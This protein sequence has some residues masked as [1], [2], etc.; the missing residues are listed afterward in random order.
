MRMKK[1]KTR[2]ELYRKMVWMWYKAERYRIKNTTHMDYRKLKYKE[3][4]EQVE[5]YLQIW[6]EIKI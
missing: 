6:E 3:L 1:P 5:E 2:L 4:K